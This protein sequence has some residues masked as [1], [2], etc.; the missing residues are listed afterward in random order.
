MINYKNK[1]LKYKQKY[2]ILKNDKGGSAEKKIY[3]SLDITKGTDKEERFTDKQLL[4]HAKNTRT[5]E[6]EARATSKEIQNAKNIRSA[7]YIVATVSKALSILPGG[8]YLAGA[9]NM[10][11]IMAE[12]YTDSLKFKE[13]LYDTM[14]ILTNCYKIF[15]LINRASDI[16]IIAIH[17][18]EDLNKLYDMINNNNNNYND[19]IYNELFKSAL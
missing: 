14:I 19:K 1:Y 12:A 5:R 18:Y 3:N 4:E 9:L 11:N 17:N 13:L 6:E 2:V 7:T 10:A 8:V 15:A 16:F